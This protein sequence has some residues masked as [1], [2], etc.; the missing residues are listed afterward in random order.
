MLSNLEA[1]EA[2]YEEFKRQEL[3]IST[4]VQLW[5]IGH[6]NQQDTDSE[7]DDDQEDIEEEPSE[8][9]SNFELSRKILDDDFNIAEN[10]TDEEVE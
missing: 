8:A 3:Q 6:Q 1:S 4:G 5:G 7:I 9:S 2:K 10:M